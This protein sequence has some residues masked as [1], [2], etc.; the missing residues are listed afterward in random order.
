MYSVA[1]ARC[2]VMFQLHAA[3]RNSK[4]FY[5][6]QVCKVAKRAAQLSVGLNSKNVP[7]Q[8]GPN[9]RNDPRGEHTLSLHV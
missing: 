1:Y 9:H 4:A 3:L 8:I 2:N 6:F 5:Y 7:R